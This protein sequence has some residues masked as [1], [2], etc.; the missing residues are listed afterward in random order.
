MPREGQP[1][2]KGEITCLKK[3]FV[4][5]DIIDAPVQTLKNQ[6]ISLKE[7]TKNAETALFFLRDA[8]CVL[9]QAYIRELARSEEIFRRIG[10]RVVTVVNASV[11]GASSV[12][13]PAAVPF[14]VVCDPEGALYALYGVGTAPDKDALGDEQTME[15]IRSAYA[16]GFVHGTH[17]GDPLRLPAWFL[18]DR[19]GRIQALHYGALGDD[20]PPVERLLQ[21]L[22]RLD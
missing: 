20:L 13:S 6:R 3:L 14:E 5:S 8:A 7:L 21:T 12:L 9:A 19:E 1:S 17:T 15:R 16:A 2:E 18:L 11:D 10:V 22:E 4:G